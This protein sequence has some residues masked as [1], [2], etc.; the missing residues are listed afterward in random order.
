MMSEALK[1]HLVLLDS[2]LN[3]SV[4]LLLVV[5]FLLLINGR[6]IIFA[7]IKYLK[8]LLKTKSFCHY[9]PAPSKNNLSEIVMTLKL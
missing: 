5:H 2:Y 3:G 4:L 6:F 8:T 1:P 9:T 7:L